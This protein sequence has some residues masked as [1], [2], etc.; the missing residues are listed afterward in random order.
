MPSRT[1]ALILGLFL[2]CF[3]QIARGGI[4]RSAGQDIAAGAGSATQV[5][6]AGSAAVADGTV[7][8]GHTAVN[9]LITGVNTSKN[10]VA[11]ATGDVAAAGSSAGASFA[12]GASDAGHVVKSAPSKVGHEMQKEARSLWH[13][14]W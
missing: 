7:S 12:H 1:L 13:S 8:A 3:A 11:A 6:G 10:G 5:A 4:I 2:A 14:I 9:F